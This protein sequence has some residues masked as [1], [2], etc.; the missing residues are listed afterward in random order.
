[1]PDCLDRGVTAAVS[2]VDCGACEV[3]YEVR[4]TEGAVGL[5]AVVILPEVATSRTRTCTRT[6]RVRTSKRL[7]MVMEGI[8]EG[9]LVVMA[10]GFTRQSPVNKLWFATWVNF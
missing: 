6:T 4:P 2:V 5:G 9:T 7:V 3:A 8:L 10:Q 1:M